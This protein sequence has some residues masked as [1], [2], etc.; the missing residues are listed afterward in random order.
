[1]TYQLKILTTAGFSLL[2][3]GRRLN[4]M[5]WASLLLLMAG[6]SLVQVKKTGAIY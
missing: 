1:M 2:L 5:Q 4:A 3:L 6:V